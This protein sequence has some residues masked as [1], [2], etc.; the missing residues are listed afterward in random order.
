MNFA[1]AALSGPVRSRR[2]LAGEEWR[3]VEWPKGEGEPAKTRDPRCQPTS[4]G[5]ELVRMA[6]HRSII[7][8]SSSSLGA[9]TL[10]DGFHEHIGGPETGGGAVERVVVPGGPRGLNLI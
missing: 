9:E 4:R 1:H 8:G 10:I 5:L 3:L 7:N 6:K 2:R